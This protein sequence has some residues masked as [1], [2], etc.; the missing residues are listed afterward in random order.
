MGK[1]ARTLKK[2]ALLLALILLL[3]SS[4]ACTA[5]PYCSETFYLMDTLITVTLYTEDEQVAEPIF[6]DCRAILTEL[7][8]LWARQKPESEIARFNRSEQGADTLD[9]RTVTLLQ[10]ALKASAATD[11]A[12]DITVAPAVELW[13]R[14]GDEARLPTQAEIDSVLSDIGYQ[15]LT[16][17]GDSLQKSRPTVQ[18]DLG[19]IGKGAA[20][21]ALIAYL[22]GSVVSGGLV[23]FGSN[24]AV[25]G[26]KPDG[27]VFQIALRD[28]KNKN[29][30]VGTL[31]MTGGK[32]L[33]VSGDYERYVMIDGVQYHHIVDPK[34]A[35][36][37]DSG[38]ASVAVICEDGALADA[39]ST[40]LFVMGHARTMEFYRKGIYDFEAILISSDG[41]VS[42]TDGLQNDFSASI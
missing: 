38:L 30:S 42:V 2:L 35:Y 9:P 16:L 36:P 41:T 31:R 6:D 10:T 29:A 12:F 1:G 14:C 22:E 28:P 15:S 4:A 18:I 26:E 5:K 20:I 23:S 37:S 3:L 34:T 27:S 25:F 13:Q 21:S 40:A 24:V 39:L 33:S 7:E 8:A 32:V 19:G 17:L 11:G